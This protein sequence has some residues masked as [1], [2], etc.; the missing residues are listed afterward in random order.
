MHA[1]PGSS[2]LDPI[3]LDHSK[4]FVVIPEEREIVLDDVFNALDGLA[5]VFQQVA[6][7]TVRAES[8][9][10]SSA[11]PCMDVPP[12]GL[13]A[14]MRLVAEKIQPLLDSP[15]IHRVLRERPDIVKAAVERMN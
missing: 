14:L 11:R 12:E 7:A 15:S 6:D 5:W 9:I 10:G 2:P 3:Y 4:S 8:A 1:A 13:A